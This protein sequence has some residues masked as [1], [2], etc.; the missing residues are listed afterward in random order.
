MWVQAVKLRRVRLL[1]AGS[2]DHPSY[3]AISGLERALGACGLL[4]HSSA[5][6]LA[7][8]WSRAVIRFDLTRFFMR[9]TLRTYFVVVMNLPAR[10]YYPQGW[11]AP[12]I[13]YCFDCWEPRWDEWERFLR[14][15]LVEVAFFT[16][17]QSAEEMARRLPGR[18]IAWM[19]EGIDPEPYRPD[20]PLASRRIDVL[21]YGRHWV[22]Y[23]EAIAPHCIARG[24]VHS[25]P[26]GGHLLFPTQQALYEGLGD[27]KLVVC[28][29]QSL[30][31][32]AYAG[33][34]STMTL[35]FLEAIASGALILGRCPPE[36]HDFFGYN[37]V[38][39]VDEN[40]P[41]RQLDTILGSLETYEPLRLRN[42][43]RLGEIGSWDARARQIMSYLTSLS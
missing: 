36:M 27:A 40:D 22:G 3:L 18:Q 30:T 10:R 20:R 7:R 14:R 31:S 19:P 6:R 9:L 12:T 23:H 26:T 25:F 2:F 24:Y 33:Q 8:V 32:P 15:N 16:S 41:R 28:V 42:L 21:E 38:I 35:R 43:D 29:P 5:G 39:E 34:V 4:R 37:P 11:W 17:R 1:D 13:V